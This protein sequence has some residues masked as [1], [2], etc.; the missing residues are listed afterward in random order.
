MIDTN[1]L[2]EGWYLDFPCVGFGLGL[3]SDGYDFHV[4]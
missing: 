2:S 1:K 3:D 4:L